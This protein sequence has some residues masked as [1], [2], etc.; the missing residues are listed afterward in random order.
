MAT[1]PV[2]EP[3]V[4]GRELEYVA[5]CIKSGWISSAGSYLERF[6]REWAQYCGRRYGVAV[7]NGTVALELAVSVLE[8]PPAAEVILPAFTIASC[9]EAVL[10]N[11]LRPV[12]V[13]CDPKTFVMDVGAVAQRI[14]PRTA[15]VMPVHIYGHPVEMAPLLSLAADQGLKIVEDA[16]EAHAAECSVGGTWRRCGS[17]GEVSCF[18]FYANKNI[19]TGEGGMVLTDRPDHAE[20]LRQRRNLCFGAI[21]RFR[22]EDRGGNFRMTNLQAA[23]GCAQLERVAELLKRKHEIAARYEAELAGLPLQLPEAAPWAR[24]S[25]WM[26]AVVL[27]E[28]VPFEARVFAE[29]LAREGIQTRPFFLGMHEQPVYRRLGLFAGERYP[30]TERI[31]RRGLYLPSGQALTEE[32]IQT[33]ASKV[34]KILS[35]SRAAARH[36]EKREDWACA[37]P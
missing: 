27:E 37:G 12:L 26:Y 14:G 28:S 3:L 5:D 34:R 1:V 15:A 4:N 30:V 29:R 11:G 2:N 36:S 35:Q 9:I 17:F 23:I 13:D 21:E 6:E 18:S 20:R 22:H 7:S 25:V 10:R 16:A 31:S 24:S 32:Q 8:L 33:V 19:T